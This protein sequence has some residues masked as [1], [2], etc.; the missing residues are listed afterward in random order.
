MTAARTKVGIVWALQQA[1]VR[2]DSFALARAF[3]RACI[4]MRAHI[5]ALVDVQLRLRVHE[6]VRARV[7]HVKE[8]LL[9]CYLREG[10]GRWRHE[11]TTVNAACYKQRVHRADTTTLLPFP[12]YKICLKF[13][14]ALTHTMV[15]ANLI[16]PRPPPKVTSK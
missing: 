8:R 16:A 1:S 10:R 2:A 3:M 15:F 5:G 13:E 6:H 14:K 9:L 7:L 12:L 4:D 11:R